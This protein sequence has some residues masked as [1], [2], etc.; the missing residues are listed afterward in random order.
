M[1]CC[2][3]NYNILYCVLQCHHTYY[4]IHDPFHHC[5]GGTV[6]YTSI[7]SMG[8]PSPS[9]VEGH[10]TNPSP[11]TMGKWSRDYSRGGMPVTALCGTATG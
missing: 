11:K 4:P 6:H 9:L 3:D 7:K 5:F 10:S 2:H 1:R 8:G